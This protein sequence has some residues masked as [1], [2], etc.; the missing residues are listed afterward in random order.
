MPAVT[1]TL[2]SSSQCVSV[3]VVTRATAPDVHPKVSQPH[4]SIYVYKVKGYPLVAYL[5][6]TELAGTVSDIVIMHQNFNIGWWSLD[7][8]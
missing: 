2:T 8:L 4:M 6:S 5:V 3:T 1:M 7:I